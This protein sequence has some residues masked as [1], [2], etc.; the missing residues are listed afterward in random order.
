MCKEAAILKLE[1][2][3]LHYVELFI[4]ERKRATRRHSFKNSSDFTQSHVTRYKVQT[5]TISTSQHL[6]LKTTGSSQNY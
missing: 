5:I 1:E 3:G 4:G 6:P 2:R